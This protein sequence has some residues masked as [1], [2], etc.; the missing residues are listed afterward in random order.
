MTFRF[1]K[2][3]TTVGVA[4][5]LVLSSLVAA[6]PA[7]AAIVNACTVTLT[8]PK[9][10]SAASHEQIFYVD[11][12]KS[13]AGQAPDCLES[14]TVAL[15]RKKDNR[16]LGSWRIDASRVDYQNGR[17]QLDLPAY[18]DFAIAGSYTATVQDAAL[19]YSWASANG[20]DYW[21]DSPRVVFANATV[22]L[23]HAADATMRLT[24]RID[25]LAFSGTVTRF[26][27]S[28]CS[29]SFVAQSGSRVA[30]QKKTGST[31]VTKKTVT[32]NRKGAYSAVIRDDAKGTWRAQA[33]AAPTHW[34]DAT[35]AKTIAKKSTGK[36]GGKVGISSEATYSRGS[37]VTMTYTASVSFNAGA[38]FTAAPKDTTVKVQKR[39]A[40]GWKTIATRKTSTTGKAAYTATSKG[41]YRFVVPE[42]KLS[43]AAT[44]ASRSW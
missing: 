3:T 43:K 9:K 8:A 36:A 11:V 41:T 4:I 7:N 39:T 2:I 26:D 14:V 33:L 24:R 44:S 12:A 17:V 25:G 22:D 32:T 27:P 20:A 42:T 16:Q 29:P 35:G 31:W 5:A 1:T 30:L 10:I 23:R 6:A 28:C 38:G 21:S 18:P 37:V 15:I 34:S 40:K 19:S 13:S